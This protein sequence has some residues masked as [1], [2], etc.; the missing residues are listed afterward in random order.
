MPAIVC[1]FLR[2]IYALNK[3][4]FTQNNLCNKIWYDYWPYGFTVTYRKTICKRKIKM[5]YI[6]YVNI[7][8][9]YTCITFLPKHIPCTKYKKL[10]MCT[11]SSKLMAEKIASILRRILMGFS[12]SVEFYFTN[13][14][15]SCNADGLKWWYLRIRKEVKN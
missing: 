14:T 8:D 10:M 13:T 9:I 2:C 5:I 6:F 11:F 7:Q 12:G 15:R 3:I 4:H 1:H